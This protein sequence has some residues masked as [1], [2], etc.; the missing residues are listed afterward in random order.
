[1]GKKKIS[2]EVKERKKSLQEQKEKS[3]RERQCRNI[4]EKR[5]TIIK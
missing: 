1:M 2:S 4:G 3:S 5:E